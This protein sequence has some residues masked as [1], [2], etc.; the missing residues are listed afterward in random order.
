MVGP[1]GMPAAGIVASK[2]H[3]KRFIMLVS[4]LP[5]RTAMAPGV[6]DSRTPRRPK[7]PQK[8]L[9]VVLSSRI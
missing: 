2:S 9:Y 3:R 7:T 4:F 1:A 6:Y 8:Q 5:S